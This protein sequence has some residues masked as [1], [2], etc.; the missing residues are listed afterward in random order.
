MDDKMYEVVKDIPLTGGSSIKKGTSIYNIHGVY[1]M[2]GGMLPEAYQEDF[3]MLIIEE[4]TH[5]WNYIVP[6]KHREAFK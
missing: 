1:Y 3:D 2:D 4:A 6:I 5:G